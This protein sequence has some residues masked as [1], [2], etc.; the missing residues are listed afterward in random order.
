MAEA[1]SISIDKIDPVLKQIDC[2]GSK[3]ILPVNIAFNQEFKHLQP[4]VE[5]KFI[6]VGFLH[7]TIDKKVP[8]LLSSIL[9]LQE[10]SEPKPLSREI[11]NEIKN[12]TRKKMVLSV[13]LDEKVPAFCSATGCFDEFVAFQPL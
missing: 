2:F 11:L 4:P 1:I 7:S 3:P 8:S 9:F 5:K 13:N 6:P 12:N 10:T